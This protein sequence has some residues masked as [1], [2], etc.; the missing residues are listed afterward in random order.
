MILRDLA[1]RDLGCF[2]EARFEFSPLTVIRG[3]NRTGKSTLV[4]ALFFALFGE[5]LHRNLAPADLIR[6]GQYVGEA[7]LTFWTPDGD[8]RLTQ[9]TDRL[10]GLERRTGPD[11]AWG[12]LE[13][14]HP[15]ELRGLLPLSPET[16]AL[17]AFFRESELIYFL[18]DVPRYN[19]TLLE[20]LTGM[21]DAL[22]VRSRF[23]KALGRARE[24]RKAVETAAP[25]NPVEPLDEE[26]ARRRLAE[27]EAVFERVDLA[28]QAAQRDRGPDPAIVKMLHRQHAEKTAERERLA[29]LLQDLPAPEKL[30]AETAELES[31]RAEMEQTLKGREDLQ[32]ALGRW[33]Q[34]AEQVRSLAAKL[35]NLQGASHCPVC[36]QPVSEERVG[37]LVRETET[38]AERAEAQRREVAARLEIH[39]KQ[40]ARRAE[41]E[42]R[43]AETG[44]KRE[45]VHGLE[46]RIAELSEQIAG[47]EADLKPFG[48]AE[49]GANTERRTLSNQ[50]EQ[51]QQEMIAHRVTLKRAE[52]QQ[53]RAMENRRHLEEADRQIL[54]CKVAHEAVDLAIGDV[55][56]HLLGRIRESVSGWSR[57]FSYLDRFDVQMTDRELL[58]VIQARGYQYKLNQMSKSERIF[59]YLLLK[60]A[61]GDALGHLGLL[62]LDDP[63][64]GLDAARKRTLAYLLAEVARHR[65]VIVT[66]NNEEFAGLF[67]DAARIDLPAG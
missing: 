29:A 10:P 60:L 4:Y 40:A 42:R 39:R 65:Q 34:K 59:L 44:R 56:G 63:A 55:G 11:E 49:D 16:A 24:Y 17:T 61:I 57:H 47:L 8:H 36:R 50:R 18:Q 22:I 51:V 46:R 48:A 66:T 53:R 25:R 1:L 7:R 2:P 52:D 30:E 35:R 13:P 58:P 12:P 3:E 54:L 37:G 27:A 15:G 19:Q 5:H 64:D 31:A 67:G 6:K 21:D 33:S 20:N 14:V 38:E 26:L 45:E 62:I 23:K 28:Y 9:R 43:L 32:Q 41:L